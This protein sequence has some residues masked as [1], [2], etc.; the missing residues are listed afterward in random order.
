[1]NNKT[2][3]IFIDESGD[4]TFSKKGSPHFILTAF[5]TLKP[6]A[7]RGAILQARYDLLKSGEDVEYFHATEDAQIIRDRFYEAIKTL[8]GYEIDA[9][10]A[11]KRKANLSLHTEI[12]AS[13]SPTGIGLRFNKIKVEEKFYKQICETLLQYIICRYIKLRSSLEINKIIVVMD[14]VLPNR[15]REFVTKAIKTYIKDNF[16]L[17]PYMYFHSTKADIN[18]QISDYC[19]WAFKK[20]WSDNEI[21]PYNEIK[22]NI[23]SEFDIFE[24]GTTFYY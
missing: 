20:K 19:C 12:I 17:V 18:S 14:Q 22:N 4:L 1:M 23:K 21:R 11:E 13:S 16:G 8:S 15:K 6:L 3:Y 7:G 10:I 9:V 24:R 5:S 2:L